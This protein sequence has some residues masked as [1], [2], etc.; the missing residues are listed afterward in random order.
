MVIQCNASLKLG[1][2][3]PFAF[4]VLLTLSADAVSYPSSP[5]D[6]VVQEPAAT[7]KSTEGVSTRTKNTKTEMASVRVKIHLGDRS[8]L[9]AETT[10]PASYSFAHK[11]GQ[12]QY[13]QTIRVQDIRELAIESY[14][15]HVVSS[16]KNGTLFEFEPNAVRI[17]LKDG[18]VF[19]LA[20]LFKELRRLKAHNGDGNFTV[21]AFFADTWRA[22]VGWSERP[23]AGERVQGGVTTPTRVAH[24]AAFTRL[25]YFETIE[26]SPTGSP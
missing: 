17:E 9:V 24:P 3:W 13:T 12:V 14:R 11:K 19:K 20:Y 1:S 2:S 16:D 7:K 21:Y 25:E 5:A 15:A 8:T 26:A 18:Q 10:I 4:L 23:Q 6:P 22:R